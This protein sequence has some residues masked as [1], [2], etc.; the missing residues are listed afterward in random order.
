[1]TNKTKLQCKQTGNTMTLSEDI[2]IWSVQ[3]SELSQRNKDKYGI[4]ILYLKIDLSS[5]SPSQQH[6]KSSNIRLFEEG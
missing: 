5:A 3:N 2:N 6:L 1:M 4:V